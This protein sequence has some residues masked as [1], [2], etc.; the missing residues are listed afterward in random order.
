MAYQ[1][2][3]KRQIEF[4]DTDMAGIVH[5]SRYFVFMETAEHEF[6]KSLGMSVISSIDSNKISWPRL[7]A[8]FDFY[9]PLR[10]E[11]VVD[12]Q[13]LVARKGRKSVTYQ[14]IFKKGDVL[15]ARGRVAA[16]CC[17]CN[18][19]EPLRATVIP[20]QISSL[21]EQAPDA[22]LDGEAGLS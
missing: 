22:V 14:S 10:F 1:F 19:G 2:H 9:E 16:A 6:L 3:T 8:S 13:I 17:I 11:D 18:P 20:E 21:I 7:S 12:I 15:V 4:S 5:F